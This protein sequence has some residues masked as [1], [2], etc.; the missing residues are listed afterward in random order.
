MISNKHSYRY[1]YILSENGLFDHY[2]DIVYI[3]TMENSIRRDSYMEQIKKYNPYNKIIIQHNIGF[4]KCKKNLYKQ[5]TV[6][7]LNDAYY[8]VFLHAKSNNY[9]NIL[10]FEDDFFFDNIK[11]DDIH[12][13]GM[14]INN[15]DY[16]I[17]NL[18]CGFNISFP[19]TIKHH[20]SIISSCSHAIIYNIKYIDFF[21][22]KYNDGFDMMCDSIWNRMDILKFKYYKPVCFQLFPI[23]EN[24]KNWPLSKFA[25]WFINLVKLGKNHKLG[26]A[27]L[28]ILGYLISFIVL[29]LYIWFTYFYMANHFFDLRKKIFANKI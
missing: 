11:K 8:H 1:E 16:H 21:I 13:I 14:F 5:N 2:I 27:I 6:H 10:I 17:Y 7:D 15:N 29:L 26:F 28:N 12:E 22:K 4:K 25:I 19:H 24:I 20:I 18:G 9:T 23:T 3:L